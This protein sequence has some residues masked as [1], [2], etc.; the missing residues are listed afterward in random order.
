V[1]V[2]VSDVVLLTAATSR[3]ADAAAIA[4]GD[5]PTTLMSRAAGHLA[6]T[7]IASA[8]AAY[9]LR[10]D[11]VVGRGDNGGDGWV[12]APLLARRGA[13]VRVIA[14]EGI[15][16]PT[17][18]AA[19]TGRAAW[20]ASGGRTLTGDV[21]DA[22][23]AA[24]GRAR[25][26]VVVDCLLGTGAEGE[27]RGSVRAA[28]A[29]INAARAGGALVVACDV[30]T[31]VSADDG[32]AVEGA[33]SADVTLAIGGAKLGLLLPPGAQHAGEVHVGRLGPRSEVPVSGVLAEA[34]A[35]RWRALTCDGARPRPFEVLGDKRDRGV[36]L[37]VAGRTGSAGAAALAGMGALAAGAG[38]VTVAVPAAVRSEVAGH[39]P[40]LM[41]IGLPDDADGALHP[42]AV[43]ALDAIAGAGLAGFDAVV[44]GPGLGTG[45]GATA[46]VTHLRAHAARLVLD[47]DA[48]NVHRDA[49][50]TLGEH[51]GELVITPH[52]RELARIAGEHASSARIRTAAALA[53]ALDAVVVAKGP[54][55]LI[56]GPD[57]AG[58]VTPLGGPELGTGGTGDVLAGMVGAVLAAHPVAHPSA[59]THGSDEPLARAVARAVWWHAAA[60]QLAAAASAGRIDAVD[61]LDALPTVLARLAV[62]PAASGTGPSGRVP[63][64]LLFGSDVPST[65]GADASAAMRGRR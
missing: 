37:V 19:A 56:A 16:A 32:S 22:L 44:A 10:V 58:W 46:V 27:L 43:H 28:A 52:A 18:S 3:A 62:R 15:D 57:G 31:G 39:H 45:A 6:R 13:Q 38:L 34:P 50:A 14:P 7:I 1:S 33:V 20:L 25:A 61:V 64:H 30:P 12:A 59:A 4:A 55:T 29:A 17:S 51:V 53:R 60:G 24:D 21:H 48:L 5:E 36:V 65:V 26:D 8:G 35:S 23:V 47:A 54:G 40:A 49:P 2:V 42:D 9:G 11:V 41:V 63:L